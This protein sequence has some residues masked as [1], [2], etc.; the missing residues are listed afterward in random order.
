MNKRYPRPLTPQSNSRIEKQPDK[1]LKN[2]WIPTGEE[3]NF[4]LENRTQ[5]LEF[6]EHLNSRRDIRMIRLM[7]PAV[8][9]D[10]KY[11]EFLKSIVNLASF[12]RRIYIVISEDAVADKRQKLKVLAGKSLIR[13]VSF[14]LPLL[15][16][17]NAG[18]YGF[19]SPTQSIGLKLNKNLAEQAAQWFNL[20]FSS[21]AKYEIADASELEAPRQLHQPSLAGDPFHP[22][23]KGNFSFGESYIL[24]DANPSAQFC[25]RD[26]IEIGIRAPKI[27]VNGI[28]AVYPEIE[29]KENTEYFGM[30]NALDLPEILF[31]RTKIAILK[32][33]GPKKLKMEYPIND[34]KTIKKIN[35][36]SIYP[37]TLKREIRLRELEV[38]SMVYQDSWDVVKESITRELDDIYLKEMLTLEETKQQVPDKFPELPPFARNVKFEWMIHPPYLP[39][40]SQ[41]DE[42]YDG[43]EKYVEDLRH[44]IQGYKQQAETIIKKSEK[45]IQELPRIKDKLSSIRSRAERYRKELERLDALEWHKRRNDESKKLKEVIQSV[46]ELWEEEKKEIEREELR[47][48][49]EKQ[50]KDYEKEKESFKKQI[51]ELRKQKKEEKDKNKLKKIDKKIANLE[52]LVSKPFEF[53]HREQ[54]LAKQQKDKR[55]SKVEHYL[56]EDIELPEPPKLPLP[57]SGI[58]Y[59]EKG[60]KKYLVIEDWQKVQ[61]ALKEARKYGADGAEVVSFYREEG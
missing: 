32:S 5:L 57:A 44:M 21:D 45:N 27:Y 54:R 10:E 11:D 60:G 36:S 9:L 22:H 26:A 56:S 8:Y 47:I 49:E 17:I 31:Y 40:G 55:K 13:S 19:C 20:I 23:I 16:I 7:L 18:S 41:E 38:E 12:D 6:M 52:K 35:D 53:K 4:P 51:E 25:S 59:S 2:V 15:I 58:L 3:M 39:K 34:A 33:F 24:D 61:D 28:E 42:L 50:R 1:S 29:L 48:E 14:P 37:Y 43:W 30:K 46:I